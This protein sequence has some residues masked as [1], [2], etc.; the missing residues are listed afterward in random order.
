M[1][2][3]T[4]ALFEQ[5]AR[6][7]VEGVLGVVDAR[8]ASGVKS[9]SDTPWMLQFAFD[10]WRITDADVQIEPLTIRRQVTKEELASLRATIV[11]YSVLHIRARIVR[12]SSVGSPQALL[13]TIVAL[14]A[15]DAALCER[16]RQLQEPV[17]HE[18]T[19]FGT[20]T[21][22]RRLDWYTAKAMWIGTPVKVR[23]SVEASGGLEAALETGHALWQQ[24][25]TWDRRIRDYAVAKLLPLKNDAWLDEEEVEL[26]AD[27]FCGRMTLAA[28]TAHPDGSFEFWHDDG[29]LFY[30]HS[31]YIRGSLSGGP[32]RADIPG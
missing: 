30:R 18:D 1:D 8:G 20:L 6:S 24:Q 26:S 15:V 16:A 32:N 4:Q 12:D 21:L 19:V 11:P 13:E 9:Q 28:V 10:G 14:D 2:L 25:A 29:D 17:T 23:F 5:L 7:P 22:D 31:I 27:E 3:K